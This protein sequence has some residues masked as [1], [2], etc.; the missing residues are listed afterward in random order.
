MNRIP[1]DD[2]AHADTLDAREW[3]AQERARLAA[4]RGDAVD[5][6]DGEAQA[7]RR[8]AEALRVPPADRLPSNFAWQMA[9]QAAMLVRA[10]R[11][12]LRL[13]HWLLRGLIALMGIAGAV[14]MTIYGADTLRSLDALSSRGQPG[15]G[16]WLALLAACVLLSGG[17][18]FWRAWRRQPPSS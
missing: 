9:R 4:K 7:Y 18:Q 14:A 5:A 12:D 10:A 8:I 16:A 1:E 13:E 17:M 11:I 2:N 15:A 6:G 3:E